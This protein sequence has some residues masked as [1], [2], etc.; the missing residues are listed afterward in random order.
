M[1]RMA[2]Y[3]GFFFCLFI[4]LAFLVIL[5][6][7]LGRATITYG[8]VSPPHS[9]AWVVRAH[10]TNR[11]QASRL[12]SRHAPWET[13]NNA[14]ETGYHIIE[15]T[16]DEYN[17]L[18]SEGIRLA[19][20]EAQTARLHTP[21]RPLPGQSK[22]IPGFPCYRT[23]EETYATAATIAADYPD[24]ATW[25]D[26]GDSWQKSQSDDS[27]Y[28][29]MAL[30]L[31]NRT[32]SE[33]ARAKPALF[34]IA[35]VHARE[36]A[37]AELATRFAEYLVEN[38]NAI[39]DVTWLLDEH[40]IHLVL[41]GN[42]D[43]RKKAEGGLLWRKN[44]NNTFCANTT[45][46]G[47]DINRNFSFQWSL[48]VGNQCSETF[49]GPVAASEPE[50][51]A[52][53][54][55]L[56]THI[57]DQRDDPI[58]A[59]APLTT[60]GLVLDLHSYSE[61]VLWPWSFT[62][63]QSPNHVELQTLGRK[64]AAFNGY[65]PQPIHKLYTAHG[66]TADFAYGELGVAAYIIE[67]G[68]EFFQ[69]CSVFEQDIVPGNLPML[70]YAAKAAFAPYR[71]PAGPD[72][73]D[74]AVSPL[75]LTPGDVVSLTATIDD[76]R[77]HTASHAPDG[78]EPAQNIA[79]AEYFIDTPPWASPSPIAYPMLPADGTFDQPAEAVAAMIPTGH[80]TIGRHTLFV[81]GQDANGNHGPVSAVFLDVPDPALAPVPTYMPIVLK[82]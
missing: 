17:R 4:P 82:Q 38:Y 67:L 15:V 59:A 49:A 65:T 8:Q 32:I 69:Q 52:I 61:L 46:R 41:I 10:Y 20:D 63:Q 80:L 73:V 1:H 11:Q 74:I 66:T 55:Y 60:T 39:A 24:L 2:R 57:A 23:V 5:F 16:Q 42:P 28:D 78:E 64:M 3:T 21:T 56:R 44:A 53:Q 34:I 77:Y 14:D 45:S 72:V 9:Q 12:A 50:T 68:T 43:G 37:P 75:R 19:I 40:T 54:T 62:T 71:V 51:Q 18:R 27:G 81:R 26:I 13:H 22:G 25:I 70:L 79:A 29:I 31:T 33:T 47:V 7:D 30:Q 48:G 35:A 58:S 6:L 36:Y 76:T